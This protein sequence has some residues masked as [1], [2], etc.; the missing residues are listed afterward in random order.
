MSSKKLL[1]FLCFITASFLAIT[2]FYIEF[3]ILSEIDNFEEPTY[4]LYQYG[5]ELKGAKAALAHF[6]NITFGISAIIVASM[7]YRQLRK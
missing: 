1:L 2:V 7:C 5:I 6:G 3:R 4:I